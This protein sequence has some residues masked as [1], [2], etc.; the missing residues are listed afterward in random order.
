[1]ATAD[2]IERELDEWIDI[3]IP[4]ESPPEG[5]WADPAAAPVV[6]PSDEVQTERILYKVKKLTEE[7]AEIREAAQ[8]RRALIDSFEADR[9]AGPIREIA[10][11]RSS[12]E[13]YARRYVRDHPRRPKT[14]DLAYGWLK[15]A[16]SGRG[17]IVVQ[18]EYQFIEWAKANRPD[19]LR[20]EPAVKKADLAN[21][22]IA[23][24]HEG[25]QIDDPDKD[26]TGLVQSYRLTGRGPW[27]SSG[28]PSGQPDS[29]QG[30][31][32]RRDLRRGARGEVHNGHR[33]P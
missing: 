17:R 28:R 10:R 21:E 8:A 27:R 33:A 4:T 26:R 16:K 9:S 18:D 25:P 29:R 31:R 1:M 30:L 7:L 22:D 12:L 3:A 24:R 6:A 2:E 11:A 19:L 15:V 5:G 13:A 32:P 20:W 14:I 23:T